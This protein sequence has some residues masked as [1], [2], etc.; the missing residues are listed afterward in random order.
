MTEAVSCVLANTE[1]NVTEI[2][3]QYPVRPMLRIFI[4]FLSVGRKF[5]LMI[6][7]DNKVLAFVIT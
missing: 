4:Y 1:R 5:D 2:N 3:F 7:S 6:V